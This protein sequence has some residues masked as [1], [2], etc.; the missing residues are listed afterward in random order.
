MKV[1]QSTGQRDTTLI[2]DVERYEVLNGIRVEREPM[3]APVA[4]GAVV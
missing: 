2:D 1:S 3:G 4:Y